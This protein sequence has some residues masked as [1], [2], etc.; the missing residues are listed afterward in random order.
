M[1]VCYTG[2]MANS[3]SGA[4]DELEA[5]HT[6]QWMSEG[7]HVVY[8]RVGATGTPADVWLHQVGQP[9]SSDRLLYEEVRSYNPLIRCFTKQRPLL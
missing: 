2:V 7:Q 5:V 8:S 1:A 3:S 4:A 9:E 6:V